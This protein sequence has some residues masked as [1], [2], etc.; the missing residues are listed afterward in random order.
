MGTYL[1]VKLLGSMMTLFEELPDCFPKWLHHFT[2]PP[3][4]YEGAKFFMVSA[5]IIIV[6]CF[7]YSHTSECEV[8][9][10]CDF[11]LHFPDG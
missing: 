7:D 1:G 11:D 3:V 5:T 10:D 8:V 4:M 9:P 2:F 6:C